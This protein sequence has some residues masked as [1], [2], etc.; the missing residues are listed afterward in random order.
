MMR[1]AVFNGGSE[2]YGDKIIMTPRCHTNYIRKSYFDREKGIERFYMENYRSRVCILE[3]SD[4][5]KF[6]SR[7]NIVL[8]GEEKEFKHGIED[9]R[10]IRF[11]NGEYVL[12]GC[13]KKIPPFKGSGGDRIAIYSTMDFQNIIYR[14][15][16]DVF[17]SRNAIIFPELIDGKLYAIF[18]FHPNIHIN[19]L[20]GGLD[21]L[22]NPE[23]REYRELWKEI[24][25]NKERSLLLEA[26]KYPHE[27]EKI[28]GGPPPIKTAEGWLMIYHAVGY[29]DRWIT[30]QYGLSEPI[31]R[32]YSISVAVLDI[33]D[34]QK[35]LYRTK[36]P[37]YIPGKPWEYRGS[38]K[39]P[40]DVPYV[41]FPTGAFIVRDRLVIY[42]GAGDKYMILLSASV[43]DILDYVVKY[44]EKVK[45]YS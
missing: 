1:G 10:I 31:S 28:G 21:Q 37:V 11:M 15:I 12:I 24:Y 3:S 6:K 14:G 29:I 17:D 9:I 32:G 13:G 18:R 44:G 20:K 30:G 2:I 23:E 7:D 22:Y 36:Y 8:K 4:G 40:V 33:N 19:E 5:I 39:Y 26:G 27:M 34:P 45:S 25:H 43:N 41:V 38:E 42:A 16:I 35:V